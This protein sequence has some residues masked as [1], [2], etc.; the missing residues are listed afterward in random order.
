MSPRRSPRCVHSEWMSQA[1]SSERP[2]QRIRRRSAPSSKRLR[3][4]RR[5]ALRRFAAIEIR[6]RAI[7]LAL[8][9]ALLHVGSLVPLL[10]A[11]ADADL[12]LHGGILPVKA[13]PDERE[14][15][16]LCLPKE[17]IDLRAMQQE[18]ARALWLVL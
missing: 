18:P 3:S 8:L 13:Q 4:T 9:R 14:S 15:L 1:G 7:G 2:A 17:A 11:F 6:H 16:D 12:D 10:L 5:F